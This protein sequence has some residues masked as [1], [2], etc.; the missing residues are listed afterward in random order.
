MAYKIPIQTWTTL[1]HSKKEK[2]QKSPQF[3]QS[4]LFINI[5]L[6]FKHPLNIQKSSDLQI[7]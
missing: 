3:S 6:L 2:A 5:V 1:A 7:Q 4:H